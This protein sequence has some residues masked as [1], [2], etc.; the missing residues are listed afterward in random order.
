MVINVE[1]HQRAPTPLFGRLV[2]CSTDAALLQDY[3]II[4]GSSDML[5][6]YKY[7]YFFDW[8]LI[9]RT[10]VTFFVL[11]GDQTQSLCML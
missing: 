7:F 5:T 11:C 3:G 4:L 9:Q 2:R 10:V 6:K 8:Y 1:T